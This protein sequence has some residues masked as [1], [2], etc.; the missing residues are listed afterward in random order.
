MKSVR[1]VRPILVL[2]DRT[3]QADEISITAPN[4]GGG[5]AVRVEVCEQFLLADM[6]DA[7]MQPKNVFIF[8]VAS[9]AIRLINPRRIK[10]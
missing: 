9:S 10:R 7:P 6:E 5:K 3:Y 8:P 1:K 2:P 4:A